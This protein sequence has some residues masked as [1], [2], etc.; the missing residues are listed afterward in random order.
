MTKLE[1][2]Q[3]AYGEHWDRVKNHVSD[4]GYIEFK[5]IAHGVT[6]E[7]H[8]E[9]DFHYTD[10]Q[11]DVIQDFGHGQFLWRPKELR[12]IDDNKGWIKIFDEEN[13]N[14]PTVAGKYEVVYCNTRIESAEYLPNN[15]WFTEHSDYPKTTE[16]VGLTHFRYPIRHELP[17]Y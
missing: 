11:V 13:I 8:Y 17:V 6:N 12:G 2:I 5:V 3:K 16:I 1:H 4:N 10:I 14:L 7:L 9:D 15:R